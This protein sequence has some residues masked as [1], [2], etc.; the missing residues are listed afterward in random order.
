MS[1]KVFI[2]DD[3]EGIRESLQEL[4]C[5][6]GYDT[7]VFNNGVELIQSLSNQK[8]DLIISDLIMPLMDGR[9]ITR[10][11]KSNAEYQK[12]PILL[13]TAYPVDGEELCSMGYCPDSHLQKPYDIHE[14]STQ[15]D[16]LI[17]AF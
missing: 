14:L 16:K 7:A 17:Q 10:T 12:I 9:E 15:I 6:L 2:V 4:I 11:V 13:L 3:N 1:K 8:P 5:F